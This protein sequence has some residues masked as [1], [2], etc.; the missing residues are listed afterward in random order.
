MGG[1]TYAKCNVCGQP[2]Q[3][4]PCLLC[5]SMIR[6]GPK[7]DWD[8]EIDHVLHDETALLL[9]GPHPTTKRRWKALQEGFSTSSDV[10][11]ARLSE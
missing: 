1:A 6:G 9:G 10:S 4:N 3:N 11:W 7:T 2:R 8:Y 5:A